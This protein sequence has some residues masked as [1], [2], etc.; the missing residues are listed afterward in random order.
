MT[1]NDEIIIED[2]PK[3]TSKTI[4]RFISYIFLEKKKLLIIAF[5][6]VL[7]SLTLAAMPITMGMGID[8]LIEAINTYDPN[9]GVLPTIIKSLG[10][11]IML[12]IITFSSSCLLA[13][14]QQYLVASVGEHITLKLRKEISS[15]LNRLPLRYF[16]MHQPG[17]IM[18][19]ITN[20]LEKV[21]TVLQVG[22]MQLISSSFTIIFSVIV[23]F[24]LSPQLFFIVLISLTLSLLAT[25]YVSTIAQKAYG[26]NM[27]SLSAL[28]SKVEEVFTGNRIIKTFNHQQATL[29]S[30]EEL[31][32]RQFIAQRKA[33]FADYTIYPVMRFL[34]Q[35]GFIASALVGGLMALNGTLSIGTVQAFLLYV[36]QIAE[37]V[38]ESSYVITSL[39][40]AIAGAERVF[41][42]LDENEEI[43]DN[44]SVETNITE[45]HVEFNHVCFGYSSDKILMH[46]LNLEVK[47]NEMVA[48]VGPTGGGKTTL[49]N[50][51]MRFYELN[52][53]SIHI[54]GQDIAKLNRNSMRR[55]IGMVLQDSWLF[56]GTIAENIAYGK[57]DATREEII[58]AAKAASCDHFIRTLPDGYDTRLSSEAMM[59]SQGQMQLLTIARAM[60]LNPTILVLDE[61]TSSV[62]TRTEVEIQKAMNRLMKDKTSFVIAHRLST[63]KNA[64]L[65]LVVK[66]GDI[67]ERGNHSE[68]LQR[69]GFYFTLHQSQFEG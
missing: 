12:M 52:N 66:D 57:Q 53:G 35:L 38:T 54:D 17:E 36:N 60:L 19:R 32:Q 62:D 11:P 56:D 16:D 18:S 22:L 25:G 9:I 67:I 13:Y 27:A 69:K 33:Q 8:R 42:L 43:V 40:A 65:I 37:P 2:I 10:Y 6:T 5:A 59:I 7:S 23:M 14:L 64:D 28:T 15:K 3:N 20:D 46:D 34:G 26:E 21:A 4:K 61:A 41:E 51:L 68:L 30:L 24:R 47:P 1:A 58:N 48:I 31:N 49:V 44:K 45:G 50:L 39:Q 29:L 55:K 63:I